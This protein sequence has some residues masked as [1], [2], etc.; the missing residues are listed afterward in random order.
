M[1]KAGIMLLMFAF[2]CV[3]AAASGF[4]SY[5]LTVKMMDESA[6][7]SARE[8]LRAPTATERREGIRNT[9]PESTSAVSDTAPFTEADYYMVRLEGESLGVYA[10]DSEKEEFLYNERIYTNDLSAR[11]F[12]ILEEG[13]HLGSISELTG[14]L[15]DFTS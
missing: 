8:E 1:K 3:T 7:V 6:A 15:E 4:I 14:F 5:S 2:V 9:M 12:S 11:D 10:C 13:V